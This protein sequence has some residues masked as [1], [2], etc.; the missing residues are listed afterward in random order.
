MIHK[1][2]L[3]VVASKY[4][5]HDPSASPGRKQP[6]E[7]LDHLVTVKVILI[8]VLI[9]RAVILAVSVPPVVHTV[10]LLS[11]LI[12]SF[13]GHVV[14]TGIAIS[15]ISPSHYHGPFRIWFALDLSLDHDAARSFL[16]RGVAV[17]G[18]ICLKEGGNKSTVNFFCR[19]Y[20]TTEPSL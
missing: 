20:A 14:C 18:A 19:V 9:A 17:A 8:I 15:R 4:G 10:H 7:D 12:N 6:L 11:A 3:P 13:L 16:G 2:C 1:H 5:Q